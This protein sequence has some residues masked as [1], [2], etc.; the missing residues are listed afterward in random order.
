MLLDSKLKPEVQDISG[1]NI[2][3]LLCKDPLENSTIELESRLI[4]LVERLIKEFKID[5]N[6]KDSTGFTPLMFACEHGNLNLIRK[7]V[8]LGSNVNYTNSEGLNSMLLAIV[9]SLPNVVKY[10]LDN[11]FDIKSSS[12]NISYITDSAYLNEDEIFKLLI[13]A[14]CDVNETK[15]DENGVILN[16]LWAACER[17]NFKIVE[18]LLKNGA[19]TIM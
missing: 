16:P 18:I 8:E 2:L 1:K 15:Q 9:N 14:G 11:G 7:L 4:T 3:H 13:D 19:K 17:S 5:I 10:L 12:K 6:C